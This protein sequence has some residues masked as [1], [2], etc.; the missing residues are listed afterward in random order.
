[1]LELVISLFTYMQCFDNKCVVINYKI[2]IKCAF[3]L[4]EVATVIGFFFF[5]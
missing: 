5:F 1:M 2:C 3:H 4:S